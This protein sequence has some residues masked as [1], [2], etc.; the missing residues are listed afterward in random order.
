MDPETE[1]ELQA[2]QDDLKELLLK[3]LKDRKIDEPKTRRIAYN[4]SKTV[5]LYRSYKAGV[6]PEDY[7]NDL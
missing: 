4:I 7:E 6:C 5:M 3:C 2:C 1:K